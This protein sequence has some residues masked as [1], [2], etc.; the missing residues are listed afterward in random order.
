MRFISPRYPLAGSLA[1]AAVIVLVGCSSPSE[2]GGSGAQG[3]GVP[4]AAVNEEA[5]ALVPAAIADSGRIRVATNAPYEPFIAFESEGDTSK[6]KGL[7]YDL[8]TAVA[9]TLGLKAEFQQQPFDGLVPGLQA[10]KYEAIVGG[11]TDNKERQAAAT[12]VD[13]SASGTGILVPKDNSSGI[14][15]LQSLCGKQVAVQK[16][17]KQVTLLASFSEENCS[18]NAITLTEYPQNTDAFNAVKAGKA[19]AFVATKVNL[20]DIAGKV[21]GQAVVLD[22]AAAPNG[23]EASPNGVGFLRS[24]AQLAGAFKAG[25]QE[26]MENGTYG[27][28]LRK[29]GQEPIGIK[30]A[31]I[32]AAID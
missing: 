4:A 19:E 22:D 10:R 14:K 8:V 28:I 26:L 16:A 5:A 20:V 18:G 25:L 3:A 12:F 32:D 24:E 6:F 11:I 7:D 9:G 31:T 15:D 21:N 2:T 1:A 17:S 13:Y 23:Y 29:W 27:E 30:E